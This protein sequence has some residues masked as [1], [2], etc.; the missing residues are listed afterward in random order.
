MLILAMVAAALA[1]PADYR[2][3]AVG[4]LGGG[5][6]T[7]SPYGDAP[8][9][10]GYGV[11]RLLFVR[12]RWAFELAAREGLASADAR[13]IGG[14][15]AGARFPLGDTWHLRAGFAHHHE[16]ELSLAAAHPLE[17]SLGSLSGIR[18][19]T[20]GELG[21]G[22]VLPFQERMLADRPG[23]GMD[24]SLV[25]FPDQNGPLLYGFID[26]SVSIGLAKRRSPASDG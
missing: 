4:G 20:G 14:I 19:R 25:A 11:G 8:S 10:V 16:V 12:D 9:G 23:V 13:D 5:A 18:H 6:G 2:L 1:G 22:F 7:V 26:A 15:Y 24:L 21:V 17:A 3:M